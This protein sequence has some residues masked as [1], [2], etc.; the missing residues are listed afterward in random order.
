[1]KN[2]LEIPKFNSEVEEADWWYE[3]RDQ[4]AEYFAQASREGRFTWGSTVL[5]R[6]RQKTGAADNITIPVSPEDRLKIHSLASE[7][8]QDDAA[9]I[10]ALVHDVLIRK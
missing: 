6:V 5:Q 9:Y 7:Q 8:R 1:M 2:Q 10:A 4:L 3:N